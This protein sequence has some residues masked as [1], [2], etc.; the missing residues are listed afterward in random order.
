MIFIRGEPM[1]RRLVFN[2]RCMEDK[3]RNLVID[4]IVELGLQYNLNGYEIIVFGSDNF[5]RLIKRFFFKNAKD[6]VES[7]IPIIPNSVLFKWIRLNVYLCKKY[8]ESWTTEERLDKVRDSVN[9]I[10]EAHGYESI[11]VWNGIRSNSYE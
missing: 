5:R 7:I 1:Q 6:V 3:Y 8:C 2:T 11:L 10:W 9:R 4:Y